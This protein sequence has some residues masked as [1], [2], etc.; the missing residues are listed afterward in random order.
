[1]GDS[2][3]LWRARR[4]Y[5][6]SHAVTMAELDGFLCNYCGRIQITAARSETLS[7]RVATNVPL[8]L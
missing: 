7:Q 5:F 4:R 8:S 1:M 2:F 3:I 6:V